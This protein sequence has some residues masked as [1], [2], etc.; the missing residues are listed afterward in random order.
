MNITHQSQNCHLNVEWGM[1]IKSLMYWKLHKL[2]TV[3]FPPLRLLLLLLQY[4]SNWVCQCCMQRFCITLLAVR[5]TLYAEPFTETTDIFISRMLSFADKRPTC[6]LTESE[7][8][9]LRKYYLFSVTRF[10]VHLKLLDS[11]LVSLLSALQEERW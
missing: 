1:K 3:H 2:C 4:L 7:Y 5:G 8:Q 10:H 9:S 6:K 11:S